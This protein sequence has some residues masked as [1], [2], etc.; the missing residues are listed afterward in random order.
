[1]WLIVDKLENV[2][3]GF[4]NVQTLKQ[5]KFSKRNLIDPDSLNGLKLCFITSLLIFL[6]VLLHNGNNLLL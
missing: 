3:L 5:Q 1:M 6:D 4:A 2:T